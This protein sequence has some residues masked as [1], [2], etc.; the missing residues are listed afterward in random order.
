[1]RQVLTY[2]AYGEKGNDMSKL[3]LA[4]GSNLN[5]AQMRMRCP[6]A[7]AIGTT[8]IKDYRLLFRGHP[9]AAVATIEKEK[10][11]S[12]P[13]ALWSISEADERALDRYEGFPRLY[14]K[15]MLTVPFGGRNVKAMAYVMTDGRPLGRPSAAYL[16]TI[17]QGYADFKITYQYEL[18]RAAMGE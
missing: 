17:R 14:I 7:I 11:S 4:Y 15:K 8:E 2:R 1:M 13:V 18:T 12:V 10:G 16:G 3:Y 5:K 6:D 9:L